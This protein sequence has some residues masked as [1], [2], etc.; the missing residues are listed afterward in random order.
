MSQADAEKSEINIGVG[1]KERR[2]IEALVS[3]QGDCTDGTP[4]RLRY[5]IFSLPRTGS[6]LL[7]VYL[8]QRGAGMPFEYFNPHYVFKFADRL[9]GRNP[10][11]RIVVPEL[12][13]RLE[14]KRTKQGM[15]GVK[16]QPD[17]LMLIASEKKNAA[18][19][20]LRRFDRIILLRRRDRLMQAVSLARARLTNQWHVRGDDEMVRVSRE[21]PILFPLIAESLRKIMEDELFMAE[22]VSAFDPQHV[23]SLWY[24]DLLGEGA[25]AAT[26]QWLAAAAGS[27]L[28]AAGSGRDLDLP[29]KMD[30]GEA[31]GIRE[32]F[33]SHIGAAPPS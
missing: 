7:S 27:P 4:T 26:A 14:A 6:D 11:G 2:H 3:E 15:F 28:A 22:L 18:R 5:A 25:L 20:I 33:L 19:T 13:A 8:R 12:F 21:S 16:V 24:E 32:R 23:R 30:E 9:G 31:R 29:R 1:E 17:Q 10:A